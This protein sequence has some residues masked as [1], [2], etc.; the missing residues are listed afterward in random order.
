MANANLPP[1]YRDDLPI[2]DNYR[3]GHW[4]PAMD[5][6]PLPAIVYNDE[7]DY[8]VLDVNLAIKMSN[9]LQTIRQNLPAV[10]SARIWDSTFWIQPG[11]T[12]PMPTGNEWFIGQRQNIAIFW[13]LR[14]DQIYKI[15][16]M[17]N[18][19]YQ[20]YNRIC[21]HNING[22]VNCAICRTCRLLVD[23]CMLNAQTM[24]DSPLVRQMF[25]LQTFTI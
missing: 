24:P 17:G 13:F 20:L 16:Y 6:R 21:D 25:E 19:N 15:L 7:Q 10:W 11:E 12:L 14:G 23:S 3:V 5:L 4:A 22:I 1:A 2:Y 8:M 18:G 9:L